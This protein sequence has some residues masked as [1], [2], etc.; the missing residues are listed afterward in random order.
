MD[1]IEAN[2]KKV[3]SLESADDYSVMTFC[4]NNYTCEI[5]LNEKWIGIDLEID[6]PDNTVH[7]G[8]VLDTDLYA[9]DYDEEVTLDI[10]NNLLTTVKALFAG[11]VHYESNEKFSYTAI[12]NE[13]GTYTV[14]YW[15]RKK[16]LFWTYVSGW[17]NECYEKSEFMKLKL[18]TLT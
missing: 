18:K 2:R 12:E 8:Y 6:T 13:D 10:Y 1:V 16:L 9:L 14:R 4:G 11:K 15:E 17:R 3:V 7:C 5:I